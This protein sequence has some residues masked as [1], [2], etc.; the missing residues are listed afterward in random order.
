MQYDHI[1]IRYGELTLKGKNRKL[2]TSQLLANVREA[3]DEYKDIRVKKKYDRMYIQLNGENPDPII[4]R[5]K[6]IFGIQN[7]SLAIRAENDEKDIKKNALELIKNTDSVQ[8]FKVSTK[9]SNK[10]FPIPSQEFNHVLGG[11]LLSHLDDISVD[12]HQPDLEV[13]VDIRQDA[14]YITS[15]KIPGAAGL[16]VGSSGKSL[17][18]L[19]GGIDSPVAGYLAMKRG[20]QLEAIHFHSPPYT[21]E[22]A[23]EKVL[24]LAERLSYYGHKIKVHIVPFTALQQ[25]IHRE[26]PN[27]YSMTVMRRVMMRISEAVAERENILSLI[28][29][30][31]LGQV[32]SQTM[33]SMHAINAVTSY[34]IIRPLIAMDKEDIIQI[35]ENID[36][37]EISIRPYEDCCTVFVPKSPKTKPRLEKVEQFEK[38]VDFSEDIMKVLEEIETIQVPQKDKK[39]DSLESLL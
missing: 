37:Y 4:E 5:C 26:I 13:M 12:V 19:S 2:F 16:P 36:M 29:G 7:M 23:K 30:E 22:R 35:S 14:T 20:V 27:S 3:L 10:S 24:D 9:R 11:F 34:P 6:K 8:T 32:A 38:N 18:L 28:T 25:K 33:E 39:E 31:S 17:L 1:I 15:K 21:S